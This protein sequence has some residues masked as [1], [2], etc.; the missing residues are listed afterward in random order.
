MQI[1][2]GLREKTLAR[3]EEHR[4]SWRANE[5]LQALYRAWYGRVREA[6]PP[7]ELGPWV[8]L[9]SG[10]GFAKEIIPE[11][12]LTDVVQAPWHDREV[13]A[14]AMPWPAQSLGGIVLFDVLHHLPE[15]TTFFAEAVRV[16]RPG[17]RIVM[18][19]PYVSPVSRVVYG[20]FHEERLDFRADP[21]GDARARGADPFDG[22]QAVPT[23]LFFK[24][25]A[26][27]ERRFPALRVLSVERLAGL[28]YAASG[29]FSRPP[30][31]PLPLWRRLQALEER[32]PAAAFRLFGF[33]L[34]AVIERV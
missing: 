20:L 32:L 12:A 14:E 2:V 11:L 33:R 16:L 24:R 19:E 15:P 25:R 18:C 13:A 9:G 22:N 1:D 29:G 8:E 7:R 31:L 30:M 34:L 3:F 4:R 28:A 5:A 17:G 6:L 27:L 26:D 23:T 10:P 21:L